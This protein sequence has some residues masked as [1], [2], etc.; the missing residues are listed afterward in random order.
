[1]TIEIITTGL[2]EGYRLISGEARAAASVLL[3]GSGEKFVPNVNAHKWARPDLPGGE[4][5]LN[6]NFPASIVPT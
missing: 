5:W 6:I 4:A 3:G 2:R 1:M